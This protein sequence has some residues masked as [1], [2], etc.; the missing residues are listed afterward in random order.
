MIESN[1]NSQSHV[2]SD[3]LFTQ[4]GP[5]NLPLLCFPGLTQYQELLHFITTRHGG[6]SEKPF[7]TFN[8]AAHVGDRQEDVHKNR[9]KLAQSL[10][11]AEHHFVFAD[12]R[13]GTN[14][15]L[16]EH[17]VRNNGI[18]FSAQVFPDSDALVTTCRDICLLIF[19]ADCVPVLLFDRKR[20]VIA[21]VHAG[22]RGTVGLI[23]Q[24][25]VQLMQSHYGSQVQDIVCAIGPAIGPCCYQVGREVLV[26]VRESFPEEEN[27][28]ISPSTG[29]KAFLDLW[30]A[31]QIQL[32]RCG[33]PQENIETACLCTYCHSDLFFSNRKEQPHTGRFA[34]GIM[35]R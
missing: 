23:C 13:H 30:Q 32:L 16:I 18:S 9:I 11:L 7:H 8:L 19:I 29:E 33:I 34:A 2:F 14:V 35:L 25:T 10:G 5:D 22:W 21:L 26:R 1:Y 4:V 17:R 12:Q 24:K 6:Y 28:I 15:S 20:K 27:L 31:N 3:I